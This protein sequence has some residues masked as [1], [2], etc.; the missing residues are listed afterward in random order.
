MVFSTYSKQCILNL[1]WK[2]YKVSAIVDCLVLE[3]HIRVSKQG[4]CQ[5]IKHYHHYGTIARKPG[6]GLPPKLS[7]AIQ[8]LIENAMVQRRWNDLQALLASYGIYVSLATIVRNRIQLGW[9]YRGSAYCQL[10][11]QQNMEKHLDWAQIYLHDN[12]DDVIWSDK[13][14]NS[15][16]SLLQK[17]GRKASSKATC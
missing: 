8:Q 15:P 2:G 12:F 5:F 10:I 6:S 11:R 3:D 17:T 7:P 9:T 4:V 16:T 14:T 1:Y 13:T